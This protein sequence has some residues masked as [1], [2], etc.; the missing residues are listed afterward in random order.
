MGGIKVA[1]FS[2]TK[3]IVFP[4]ILKTQSGVSK[5][6]IYTTGQK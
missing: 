4:K 3:K 6:E 2:K 5:L 1:V